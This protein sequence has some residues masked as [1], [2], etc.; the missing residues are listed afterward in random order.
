MKTSWD[1]YLIKAFEIWWQVGLQCI[2]YLSIISSPK[3]VAP[4][5]VHPPKYV[6]LA[7]LCRNPPTTPLTTTTRWKTI[8][9]SY[10]IIF[11]LSII[12]SIHN[13]VTSTSTIQGV[14]KKVANM[15]ANTP[16]GTKLYRPLND[17]VMKSNFLV[18]SILRL[19]R[20]QRSQAISFQKSKMLAKFCPTASH[21]D[22]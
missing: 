11:T 1:V 17:P 18:V 3:S 13:P 15:I 19:S 16:L 8:G 21:F 7:E 22:H 6:T 4:S 12:I 10:I 20:I 5:S 2:Y 14:S 9:N